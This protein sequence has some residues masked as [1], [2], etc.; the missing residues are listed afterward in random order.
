MDGVSHFTFID[1]PGSA[2]ATNVATGHASKVVE[3]A[4][5]HILY[6]LTISNAGLSVYSWVARRTDP[7]V[8]G[9]VVGTSMGLAVMKGFGRTA[10][11]RK[12]GYIRGGWKFVDFTGNEYCWCVSLMG[13]T[14]KLLDS[15]HDKVAMFCCIPTKHRPIVGH[16]SMNRDVSEQLLSLVL[17]TCQMVY[18]RVKAN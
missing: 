7:I 4:S 14:W 18:L 3:I 13:S 6:T 15:N 9:A 8:T 5:S 17:L 11:A 1:A 10:T 2:D 16:L 12:S